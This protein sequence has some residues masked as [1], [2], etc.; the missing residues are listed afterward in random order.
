MKPIDK[1]TGSDF[2]PGRNRGERASFA[3]PFYL[4]RMA[5]SCTSIKS[6]SGDRP[7][8]CPNSLRAASVRKSA[9][10]GVPPTAYAATARKSSAS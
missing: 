1:L 2:F 8:T 3:W 4:L 7:L 10:A 6:H 9:K 5:G